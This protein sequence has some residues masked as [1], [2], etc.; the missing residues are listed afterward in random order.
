MV[1][2]YAI[3]VSKWRV[4]GD[5]DKRWEETQLHVTAKAYW[6]EL[7][8]INFYGFGNDTPA[9]GPES[10][11]DADQQQWMVYPTLAYAL[12]PHS[13]IE[14]GPVFKYS[15]T[16]TVP[17]HYLSDTRPY[18]IGEF[19]QAGFRVGIYKDSRI[20]AKDAYRGFLVDLSATIY[21]VMA[22]VTSQFEVY[23][24]ATAAYFTFPV[25]KRPFLSLKAGAKKVHGDFP[26]HEAAFVGGEPSERKLPYQRY[27]GDEAVYG[28]A[29]LRIPVVGFPL[30][31][32]IDIGVYVYGNSGRVYV[33]RQSPDGWHTS[34]GAGVWI[35][36]LNPSSGV[37]VDLGN[38]VGRNIVQAKIGFSF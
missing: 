11:Y 34:R 22:D 31:L 19:G 16:D 27:G 18:G 13:D 35:G 25:I 8:V 6:S 24:L 26:F 5:A 21:P 10:Y 2:E 9:T 32:P 14:M 12:G 7:E 17:G 1:G 36:I 29:E 37:E 3:G 28:S 4:L 33:D 30:I 20:R 15:S 38:Y 23:S